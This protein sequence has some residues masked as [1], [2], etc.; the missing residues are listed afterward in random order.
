[1]GAGENKMRK[2][3]KHYDLICWNN[4]DEKEWRN[5]TYVNNKVE[6]E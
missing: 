2:I 1:M 5:K 4:F 3:N 6:V